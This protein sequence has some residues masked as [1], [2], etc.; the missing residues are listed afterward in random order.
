VTAPLDSLKRALIEKSGNDNGWEITRT[1][2]PLA[3]KLASAHHG[4]TSEIKGAVNPNDKNL[5]FKISFLGGPGPL[6]RELSRD[7]RSSGD[8]FEAHDMGALGRILR[9]AGELALSLPRNAEEIFKRKIIEAVNNF[10]IDKTE[11]ERA[12]RQRVG[13]DIFRGALTRYWGGACSVTGVALTEV[14]RASH[15]KPWADCESDTERLNVYN[16]FLLS[17]N[18][19]ALFDRGLISFDDDGM[20]LLSE[21]IDHGARIRLNINEGARTRWIEPEHRPYL[22]WHRERIFR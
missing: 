7:F 1:S 22:K 19:D 17:A 21:A 12:V 20:M 14:L 8:L 10:T 13:Q 3:V 6:V 16:G 2:T 9:R 5:I 18:L 15:A 11:I 4:V